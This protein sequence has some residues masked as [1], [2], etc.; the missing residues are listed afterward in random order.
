M[1][2]SPVIKW[3]GSKRPLAPEILNHFPQEI[4]TYYE[5][6]CGGCSILYALLHSNIKTNNFICNDIN[7]DVISFFNHLKQYPEQISIEYEYRW[8]ELKHLTNMNDKKQYYYQIRDRFNKEKSI[9]DFVF[10][11]RT[12]VNGLIRYNKN[13]HFNTSYHLNRDGIKPETYKQILIYWSNLLNINNVIFYNKDYLTFNIGNG[14]DFLFLDPPY[15]NTKYNIYNNKIDMNIFFN[16]LKE[17]KCGY[18]L[19]FDGKRDNI[20]YS[21][22][23]PTDIYDQHIYLEPLNSSFNRLK[24]KILTLKKVYI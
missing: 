3:T 12:A 4:D 7:N 2:H 19:T 23:V 8:K 10:L 21:Y 6:F 5:L 14:D 1:K 22:D 15:N 17:I 20:D 13:G 11:N 18:V 9:Y 24:N 16:K